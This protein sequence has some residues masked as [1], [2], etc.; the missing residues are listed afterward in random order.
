M[1]PSSFEPLADGLAFRG[2]L[3]SR[4]QGDEALQLLDAGQALESGLIGDSIDVMTQARLG[5]IEE[6]VQRME[7]PAA[8]GQNFI[9]ADAEFHGRL[10]E[11]LANELLLDLLA[12][13][14]HRPCGRKPIPRIRNCPSTSVIPP[15]LQILLNGRWRQWV[16]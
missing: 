12:P 6:S 8:A 10:F 16:G 5:R 4:Y 2:R 7:S 15:P 1:E 3:S 14:W 13:T 9:E 11:P